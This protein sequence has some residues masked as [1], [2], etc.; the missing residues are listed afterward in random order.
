MPSDQKLTIPDDK[1]NP[2]RAGWLSRWLR[3][4]GSGSP[5][6]IVAVEKAIADLDTPS[7]LFGDGVRV[8]SGDDARIVLRALRE[9]RRRLAGGLPL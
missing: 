4:R 6:E 1:I 5:A 7:V 3:R 8:L 2:W 9:Y